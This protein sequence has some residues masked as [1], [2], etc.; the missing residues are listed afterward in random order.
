MLS[1]FFYK[2]KLAHRHLRA[3]NVMPEAP[4]VLEGLRAEALERAGLANISLTVWP[5]FPEPLSL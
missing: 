1:N 2:N 5:C 3:R 4:A